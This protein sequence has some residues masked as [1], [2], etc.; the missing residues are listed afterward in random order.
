MFSKLVKW[1]DERT[2][3]DEKVKLFKYNNC[4]VLIVQAY[5]ARDIVRICF[6]SFNEFLSLRDLVVHWQCGPVVMNGR[7]MERARS[8]CHRLIMCMKSI[9]D[10]IRWVHA[11]SGQALKDF[12]VV[13]GNA[14]PRG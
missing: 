1:Y 12:V 4:V 8:D 2:L 5:R 3:L 7:I 6:C 9:Q 14:W 10:A 13:R 11:S